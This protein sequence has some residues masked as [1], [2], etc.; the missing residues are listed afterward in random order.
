M[1]LDDKHKSFLVSVFKKKNCFF[2]Q[3][4]VTFKNRISLNRKM[5]HRIWTFRQKVENIKKFPKIYK[6]IICYV[7]SIKAFKYNLKI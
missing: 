7:M 4:I 6:M 2:V 3:T 5:E 1:N